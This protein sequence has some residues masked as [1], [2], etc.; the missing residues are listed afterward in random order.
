MKFKSILLSC[1]FLWH[2]TSHA[3]KYLELMHRPEVNFY[4]V[5][6]SAER[7]F[8]TIDKD[9]KGNGYKNFLRWKHNNESKY[10]PDGNRNLVSPLFPEQQFENFLSKAKK[11]RSIL[12]EWNELGPR[13][14]DTITGHYAAGL[15]RVEDV[16]VDPSNTNKIYLGSRSGGFWKTTN[17]GASWINTTDT[18]FATGVNAISASPTNSDSVLINC[19]NSNNGTSHGIYRSTN[20]G[21]TWQLTGFNPSNTL[22]GGLGTNFEINVIAYHPAISK[23]VFVASSDGLFRSVDAMQTWTNVLPNTDI[24]QIAFHPTNPNIIYFYDD[25]TGNPNINKV[26][27]TLNAGLTFA[28][29]A[30]LVNNSNADLRLSTSLGCPNCLFAGSSNGIWKSVDSGKNFTFLGAFG[31][32]LRSLA[33]HTNDPNKWVAGYVDLY[34]STDGG[35][36]FNQCSWW[37]L[38]SAEHNGN[39]NAESFDVSQVYIHADANIL[40][41]I[42]GVYYAGTDGYV[43]KSTDNGVSW[44]RLS[45]GT[46][47]RENYCIGTSQSNHYV[48]MLGS[49]DNG[50][51]I[52]N[53]NG[54]IEF[55]GADGMEG[56]VHPLNDKWIIGSVQYGNRRRTYD[57]GFT[58]DGISPPVS[59]GSWISPINYSPNNPMVLYD[60]TD[61]VMKSNNFG[62][63]WS[64]VGKATNSNATSAAIA[65]N[66]SNIIVYSTSSNIYK[67]TDAGVTWASIKANLPS[68]AIT[69]IAF[70]P[71][72]DQVIAVTYNRYQQ[73]GNKVFMTTNGG[74]SW[75]NITYNLG[76]MPLKSV[77]IDHTPNRNIYIGAEIGIYTKTMNGNTWNLFSEKLPNVTTNELEICY[78]SNTLKAATWGRGLWENSLVG[79]E[80][81]PAILKTKITNPPDENYPRVG[82][83]QFVTST[84]SYANTLNSVWLKWGTSPTTLSN[85]IAMTNISDSTWKSVSEIQS[86]VPNQIIYFKV[87]ALGAQNDT[88]ETYRFAYTIRPYVCCE[89]SGDTS[90]GNLYLQK[91]ELSNLITSSGNDFYTYNNN[92]IINLYPNTNY[93]LTLEGNTGWGENDYAAWIDFNGNRVFD[94][95][96]ET[97]LFKPNNGDSA[98]ATFMLPSSYAGW[99]TF[100]MR[101]RISYW[102]AKPE[103]CGVTF[104]EVEDYAV[105]MHYPLN[106]INQSKFDLKIYPNPADEMLVIQGENLNKSEVKIYNAV[107]QD[108]SHHSTINSL[109]QHEIQLNVSNLSNGL[110]MISVGNQRGRFMKR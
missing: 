35:Q 49:Q 32:S 75:T 105:Q 9:K 34:N 47:I 45:E 99:D 63:S 2:F 101:V 52:R 59:D 70:D 26:I 50:E 71:Q 51:S 36:S 43:V 104:G 89:A 108:V 58:Q 42:N 110:Y 8:V 7:F 56:I 38:G 107:G 61:S 13:Y 83:H 64:Y 91:V 80:N 98:T 94:E 86:H 77:V 10:F 78:G 96:Q 25:A 15:G 76:S 33:V 14:I 48:S 17:G 1:T 84:I 69:D 19:R 30:A 90:A 68:Y 5:V 95:P 102:G 11:T 29:S 31:N 92:P 85:T 21:N 87:Y 4:T 60:F 103:P 62:N 23:L 73:D 6:D 37:S 40:K 109:G 20:G 72:D 97:V 28:S 55:Y 41:C 67:S 44:Q 18:L 27:Y 3:Q 100:R 57:G 74:T 53:E 12:T 16:F 66:N 93:T 79:R 22:L 65:E 82:S 106:V 39:T 46:G 54:W 88:S 24:T 81:F